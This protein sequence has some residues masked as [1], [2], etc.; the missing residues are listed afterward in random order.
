M[1]GG[2]ATGE[3]GNLTFLRRVRIR[4][5]HRLCCWLGRS[6]ICKKKKKKV[7]QVCIPYLVFTQANKL[8]CPMQTNSFK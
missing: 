5:G 8:K 7:S 1:E 4:K 3:K 6:N 2:G